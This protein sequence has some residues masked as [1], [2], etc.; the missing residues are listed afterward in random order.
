MLFSKRPTSF[1]LWSNRYKSLPEGSSRASQGSTTWAV[2]P[3]EFEPLPTNLQT[4]MNSWTAAGLRQ[5]PYTFQSG[6][7]WCT[8]S[9][10]FSGGI[11]KIRRWTGS[12]H[13]LKRNHPRGDWTGNPGHQACSKE[14]G[15]NQTKPQQQQQVGPEWLG[16]IPGM[17][18]RVMFVAGDFESDFMEIS[19]WWFRQK[20]PAGA[21]VLGRLSTYQ[22]C[23]ISR[24]PL[25][26]FLLS[27]IRA[28]PKRLFP[29]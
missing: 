12:H 24:N 22:P 7:S 21:R 13:I 3:P 28:W 4:M 8:I 27:N 15:V 1:W 18:G 19:G 9:P 20:T 17:I 2:E 29:V 26:S 16:Y 10:I 23:A 11:L 14:E 5:L 25:T 6:I